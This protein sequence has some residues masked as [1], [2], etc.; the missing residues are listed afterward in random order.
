MKGFSYVAVKI[1]ICV[2]NF[3]QRGV[4]TQSQIVTALYQDCYGLCYSV[5][6]IKEP[7]LSPVEKKISLTLFITNIKMNVVDCGASVIFPQYLLSVSHH[8]SELDMCNPHTY[9]MWF[10]LPSVGT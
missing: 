1:D 8:T 4:C 9:G 3:L 6:S 7:L 10:S 5:S 2:M